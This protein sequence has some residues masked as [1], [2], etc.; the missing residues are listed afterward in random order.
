MLR[1]RNEAPQQPLD[2]FRAA[3]QPAA[4]RHSA[5]EVALAIIVPAAGRDFLLRRS[6]PMCTAASSLDLDGG[7]AGAS[8]QTALFL[9][10]WLQEGLR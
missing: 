2:E 1:F 6:A 10:R 3:R 8:S 5:G 9:S 7:G 4:A